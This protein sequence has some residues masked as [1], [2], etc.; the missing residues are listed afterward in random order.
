MTT[1]K[2]IHQSNNDQC[3]ICNAATP[4]DR[5]YEHM[6][7]LVGYLTVHKDELTASELQFLKET[8]SNCKTYNSSKN[9]R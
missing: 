2:K 5:V 7:Y 6:V 4:F 8:L 9:E 3:S 1:N